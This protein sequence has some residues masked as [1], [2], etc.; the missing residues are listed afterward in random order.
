MNYLHSTIFFRHVLSYS[1][2]TV[3]MNPI[4]IYFN[5]TVVDM[6]PIDV[7]NSEPSEREY[8]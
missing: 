7:E 4:D 3:P 1:N 2:D 5:E 8:R 6:D